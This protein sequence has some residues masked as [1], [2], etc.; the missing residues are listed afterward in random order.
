[1]LEYVL[2]KQPTKKKTLNK[3]KILNDNSISVYFS[4]EVKVEWS[5]KTF[6]RLNEFIFVKI[7]V[8]VQAQVI[9]ALK[10]IS[11]KFNVSLCISCMQ[12]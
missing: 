3:L 1:M 8:R 10:C 4:G 11:H 5:E 7:R 9:I 12:Q 2:P 6:F